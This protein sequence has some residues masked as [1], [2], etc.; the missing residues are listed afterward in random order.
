MFS[1]SITLDG[2]DANAAISACNNCCVEVAMI[3]SW[4]C[5]LFPSTMRQ[6]PP[7]ATSYEREREREIRNK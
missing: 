1:I 7:L 6:I 5:T 2:P 4:S 3:G